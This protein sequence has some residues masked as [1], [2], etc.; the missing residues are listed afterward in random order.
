MIW[1]NCRFLDYKKKDIHDDEK[2][3]FS[4]SPIDAAKYLLPSTP[5]D[6]VQE[7]VDFCEAQLENDKFRRQ[8]EYERWMKHKAREAEHSGKLLKSSHETAHAE[9]AI[10]V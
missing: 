10:V 1:I 7:Y 8:E 3:D 2:G 4:P 5:P 9:L 6:I